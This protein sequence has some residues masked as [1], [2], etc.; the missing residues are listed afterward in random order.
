M[1]RASRIVRMQIPRLRPKSGRQ[2]LQYRDGGAP[3]EK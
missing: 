3:I 2:V 1:R